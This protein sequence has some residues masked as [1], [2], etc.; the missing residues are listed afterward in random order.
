MDG[1]SNNKIFMR[2]VVVGLLV[3]TFAGIAYVTFRS[4]KSLFTDTSYAPISA[5]A[6]AGR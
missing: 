1:Q 3:L 6:E 4:Q 2:I 5:Y